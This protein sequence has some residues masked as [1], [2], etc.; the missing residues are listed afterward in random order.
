MYQKEERQPKFEF[1]RV[2]DA[3]DWHEFESACRWRHELSSY[4]GHKFWHELFTCYLFREFC[5]GEAR[6]WAVAM[7]FRM[8]GRCWIKVSIILVMLPIIVSKCL[9]PCDVSADFQLHVHHHLSIKVAHR[10]EQL[11]GKRKQLFQCEQQLQQYGWLS[12]FA[13]LT[14]AD[15]MFL[16]AFLVWSIR[17]CL[18][19]KQIWSRFYW[20]LKRVFLGFSFKCQNCWCGILM[21]Y[22]KTFEKKL[23]ISF[24]FSRRRSYENDITRN[25]VIRAK[26]SLCYVFSLVYIPKRRGW[27]H[28][29][30]AHGA[31][32]FY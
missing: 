4:T 31:Y 3:C 20:K 24:V 18:L 23:R 21:D 19:W 5:T 22:Q 2:E 1:V 30:G 10:R 32:K 27:S 8:A 29:Q 17:K 12:C 7:V 11:G 13:R 9:L 25:L 28:H 15:G 14:W 26:K 6:A 16:K